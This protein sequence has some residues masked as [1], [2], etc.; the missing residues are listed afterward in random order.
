MRERALLCFCVKKRLKRVSAVRS[1]HATNDEAMVPSSPGEGTLLY[2]FAA[3]PATP[4]K[5]G[6][7]ARL[8]GTTLSAEEDAWSH[9]CRLVLTCA[10]AQLRGF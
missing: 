2:T 7:K 8:D 1:A 10:H 3:A 6:L 5:R 4:W 9:G